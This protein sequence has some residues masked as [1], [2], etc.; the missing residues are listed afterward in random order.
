MTME[1]KE[2]KREDF[3]AVGMVGKSPPKPAPSATTR[4]AVPAPGDTFDFEKQIQ[5]IHEIFR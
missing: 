2:Y 1:N 3:V 4:K 5:R